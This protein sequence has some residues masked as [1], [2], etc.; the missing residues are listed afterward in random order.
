MLSLFRWKKGLDIGGVRG[1]AVLDQLQL[2]LLMM[3][4]CMIGIYCIAANLTPIIFELSLYSSFK[5][6]EQLI[7][8][9]A[10]NRASIK[11]G[12]LFLI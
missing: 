9:H 2:F 11:Y 3:K 12:M 7:F 1:F 8:C 6:I 4:T 10:V 5:Q